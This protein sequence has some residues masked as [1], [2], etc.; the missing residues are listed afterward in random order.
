[1]PNGSCIR[2]CV[3]PYMPTARPTRVLLLSAPG[4]PSA[5]NA[6]TG[7]TRNIP[8]IRNA[9]TPDNEVLARHS[10]GVIWVWF[11]RAI[12]YH[13]KGRLKNITPH[14]GCI[15]AGEAV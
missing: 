10:S 1:M 8:S 4:R 12:F 13:P 6:S 3:R 9:Y 11:D 7:S 2:A 15:F 14:S 5:Y